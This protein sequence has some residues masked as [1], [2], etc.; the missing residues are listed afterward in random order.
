MIGI[1]VTYIFG[2]LDFKFIV[3]IKLKNTNKKNLLILFFYANKDTLESNKPRFVYL[4]IFFFE[5]TDF[6][7]AFFSKTI[8]KGR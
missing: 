4:F 1:S 3:L 6:V 7:L 8:N 2:W 5:S